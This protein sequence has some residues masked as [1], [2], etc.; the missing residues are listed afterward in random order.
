MFD[1][2]DM[3]ELLHLSI[4]EAINLGCDLTEYAK[5]KDSS[6]RPLYEG[7]TIVAENGTVTLNPLPNTLPID[8]CNSD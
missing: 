7:F 2:G 6:N 5:M 8:G 4:G 1:E 3:K